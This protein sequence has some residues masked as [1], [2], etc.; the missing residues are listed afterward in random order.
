[1]KSFKELKA[2][3]QP[4]QPLGQVII[5]TPDQCQ[6]CGIKTDEWMEAHADEQGNPNPEHGWLMVTLDNAPGIAILGC[7]NCHSV[8]F[9]P[10]AKENI[11][12][13]REMQRQADNKRIAVASGLIDPAGRP[14]SLGRG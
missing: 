14:I 12:L 13:I 4:E 8:Y 11:N 6:V 2:K 3:F 10:N 7:P 9:N 1:M 5:T